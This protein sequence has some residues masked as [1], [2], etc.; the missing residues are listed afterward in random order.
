M[1]RSPS[2]TSISSPGSSPISTV[3]NRFAPYQPAPTLAKPPG[4]KTPAM[5]K[6]RSEAGSLAALAGFTQPLRRESIDQGAN[7]SASSTLVPA[8]QPPAFVRSQSYNSQ[9][10]SSSSAQNR[11]ISS[12]LH[13]MAQSLRRE[14]LD[15]TPL[16]QPPLSAPGF[17]FDLHSHSQHGTPSEAPDRT[18]SPTYY[19]RPHANSSPAAPAY[20]F[21]LSAASS[22]SPAFSTPPSPA[23]S[24][25]WDHMSPGGSSQVSSSWSTSSYHQ[26]HHHPAFSGSGALTPSASDYGDSLGFET[27]QPLSE[28]HLSES[29][30][31][32]VEAEVSVYDSPAQQ[33]LRHSYFAAGWNRSQTQDTSAEN[34]SSTPNSGTQSRHDSQTNSIDSTSLLPHFSS[35]PP[36]P[37]NLEDDLCRSNSHESL[38]LDAKPVTNFGPSAEFSASVAPDSQIT[39][40][41]DDVDAEGTLPHY[42][43]HPSGSASLDDSQMGDAAS[44]KWGSYSK[45]NRDS[46]TGSQSSNFQSL[47][48][49]FTDMSSSYASSAQAVTSTRPTFEHHDSPF[50][51]SAAFHRKPTPSI[52]HYEEGAQSLG[53]TPSRESA[54]YLLESGSYSDPFVPA[55]H[56]SSPSL[57]YQNL[58]ASSTNCAPLPMNSHPDTTAVSAESSEWGS[59]VLGHST[60]LTSDIT[61]ETFNTSLPSEFTNNLPQ[62]PAPNSELT[63]SP[64]HHAI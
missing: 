18:F 60:P 53:F 33:T 54:P 55:V 32:Q 34:S 29:Q 14:P 5:S 8:Y 15:Q 50:A 21:M 13:L 40:K 6:S 26:S 28:L 3:S 20:P 36:S 23:P 11:R 2:A 17:P 4:I 63:P 58:S 7:A 25:T 24:S 43:D 61:R 12:P 64:S 10:F 47:P 31:Q 48:K 38:Q 19:R 30:E 37:E 51:A 39:V 27:L 49:I 62:R 44:V 41:I 52:Q 16:S 45:D 57:P 42:T 46:I 35:I 22:C 56:R 1:A 59:I 9:G